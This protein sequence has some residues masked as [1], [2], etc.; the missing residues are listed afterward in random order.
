MFI[1]RRGKAFPSLPSKSHHESSLQ[2]VPILSAL[3]LVR[4]PFYGDT[5]QRPGINYSSHAKIDIGS[6]SVVIK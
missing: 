3:L 5:P 2:A 4:Y 1:D 6:I